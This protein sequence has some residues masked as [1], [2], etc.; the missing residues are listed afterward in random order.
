MKI[1]VNNHISIVGFLVIIIILCAQKCGDQNG[2]IQKNNSALAAKSDS[3]KVAKKEVESAVKQSVFASDAATSSA[4]KNQELAAENDSLKSVQPVL[5][6]VVSASIQKTDSS[7]YWKTKYYTAISENTFL[8]NT[9]AAQSTTEKSDFSKKKDSI[10]VKPKPTTQFAFGNDM[11]LPT[12]DKPNYTLSLSGTSAYSA[13]RNVISI[14]AGFDLA[15]KDNTQRL[16]TY[17]SRDILGR[18]KTNKLRFVLAYHKDFAKI[19][20]FNKKK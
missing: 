9:L 14:G 4:R 16:D 6:D 18:D 15:N 3:L 17:L 12:G 20:K 7:E 11:S 8:K 5:A 13:A 2:V 1:S 10:K 19:Y